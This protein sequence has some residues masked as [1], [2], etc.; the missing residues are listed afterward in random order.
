[1]TKELKLEQK[2]STV[3]SISTPTSAKTV[4]YEKF[5]IEKNAK[6]K[7]YYFIMSQG[8]IREFANFI[9]TCEC[10]DSHAAIVDQLTQEL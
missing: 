8:L 5:E 3:T 1:M 10:S 6:N 9:R 4:S 7:A 2:R